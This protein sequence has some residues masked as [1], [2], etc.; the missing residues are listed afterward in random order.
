M[1]S[2]GFHF[3][4]HWGHDAGIKHNKKCDKSIAPR[5]ACGPNNW[6]SCEGRIA[7]TMANRGKSMTISTRLRA[8]G[9]AYK[10][11]HHNSHGGGANVLT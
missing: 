6:K 1:V 10:T 11:D 2:D 9:A 4:L 7:N 3:E 8:G 5:A